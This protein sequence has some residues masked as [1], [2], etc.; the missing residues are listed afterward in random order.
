MTKSGSNDLNNTLYV[1]V[2]TLN[3]TYLDVHHFFQIVRFTASINQ[4]SSHLIEE[5]NSLKKEQNSIS[6][7]DEFARHSKLERKILKLRQELESLNHDT[8]Y[9][10]VQAKGFKI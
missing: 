5:I 8:S 1:H 9:S 4:E 2:F 3:N 10:R 6:Q 7:V